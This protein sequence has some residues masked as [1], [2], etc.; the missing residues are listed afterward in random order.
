VLAR[1]SSLAIKLETSWKIIKWFI[2]F[3]STFVLHVGVVDIEE[4]VGCNGS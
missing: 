1:A 4:E 3:L 2:P